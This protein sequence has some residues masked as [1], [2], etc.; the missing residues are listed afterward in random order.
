MDQNEGYVAL[1]DFGIAKKGAKG[2][3]KSYTFCGTHEY[4][5]PEFLTKKGGHNKAVDWWCLGV[6]V[7]ELLSGK[8]PFGRI[9]IRN[10]SRLFNAILHVR[11]NLSY[12][13]LSRKR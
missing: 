12:F 4:L 1:T 10:R 8:H 7:Y 9:D 11:L 13:S 3:Q 2:L 5:A 6:M